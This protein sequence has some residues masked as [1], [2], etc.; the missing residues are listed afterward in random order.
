M[1][2]LSGLLFLILV[3]CLGIT[4]S[5]Q[6]EL[7]NQ[8]IE[9]IANYATIVYAG[10][11]DTYQLALVLNDALVAFV[12]NP[13]EESLL[14]A[15]EAW[16]AV[17]DVYGQTEAYRFYG[18]AID[19]DNGPE[20]FL[21]AWPLD[22]AYI[23]YVEGDETAGIINNTVDYPE[24]NRDLLL[25]LN[26]EGGEENISVGFHAIEFLLWG[27]DWND[28]S[29]GERPYTDYTTAANAE[30][31]GQYLLTLGELLLEDLDYLVQEWSPELVTRT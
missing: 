6:D 31:R 30:R 14:A 28:D 22:E 10:Y 20:P 24:I 13:S 23:D 7:E 9:A 1:N 15:R 17:R 19:G 26:E 3:F 2:K 16:L 18:G 27:Q 21:N 4:T 12:E 25:S 8:K 11:E 29:A 5:A